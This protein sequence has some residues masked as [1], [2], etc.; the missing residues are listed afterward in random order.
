MV[1]SVSNHR[2]LPDENWRKTILRRTNQALKDSSEK[3]VTAQLLLSSFIDAPYPL[4]EQAST[5]AGFEGTSEDATKLLNQL[6]A[7]GVL[8]KPNPEK[9]LFELS[10]PLPTWCCRTN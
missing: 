1:K 3:R 6:F 5:V 8:A 4:G 2:I 10:P 7:K 9:D